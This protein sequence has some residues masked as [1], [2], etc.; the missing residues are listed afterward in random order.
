MKLENSAILFILLFLFQP[1]FSQKRKTKTGNT[2][3][4]NVNII[5]VERKMIINNMDIAISDGSIVK[6]EKRIKALT[7][8]KVIDLTD[9]YV[10]P[11]IIDTHTHLASYQSRES[12]VEA[13]AYLVRHGVTSIRDAGGDARQL[14]EMKRA[15]NT[16]DNIGPD[17][18]YSAFMGSKEY[19]TN[20]QQWA[21]MAGMQDQDFAPW[22]QM[23]N[24]GDD[25]DIAMATAKASG[26]TGLKIYLAYDKDFLKQLV[27][28]AGK[29]GLQVWGHAMMYPARPTEVAAAGVRVLSHAFMLEYEGLEN[30]GRN[31]GLT[32]RKRDSIDF[33]N[34]NLKKFIQVALEKD[35][36]LDATVVI[37][38]QAGYKHA[39]GYVKK[40][41]KAG[42][43]ISAGTDLPV[44]VKDT[45]PLIYNEIQELVDNCGF[46]PI[47]ALRSATIIAAETFQGHHKKGSVEVGKDADLVILDG[48]P[49]TDIKNLLKVKIVFKK[50]E[51]IP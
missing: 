40:L 2:V 22:V 3:L 23:V 39:R 12:L 26:A 10:I 24:P 1:C 17:I 48:N 5:D 46:S 9:K 25:L 20:K 47:D 45:Y 31:V 21:W 50:G 6:I 19:F 13:A 42:V 28:A 16:G 11:G 34:V 41:Y 51:I 38:E 18:Y 8:D 32:L 14:A 35:V 44:V 7:T 43:K 15:I 29:F 27:S 4:K 30:P 33:E 49:L 37:G 36:I